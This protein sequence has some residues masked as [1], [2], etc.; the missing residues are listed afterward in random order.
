[1]I[2]KNSR[3]SFSTAVHNSSVDALR[4]LVRLED[5]IVNIS[6]RGYKLSNGVEYCYIGLKGE[7]GIYYSI[8]AYGEEALQ[9]Y[10]EAS[11]L[12]ET[13]EVSI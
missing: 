12:T 7:N 4:N 10:N 11:T 13:D 5:R 2:F 1:L 9:L 3:L 6:P 8:Q